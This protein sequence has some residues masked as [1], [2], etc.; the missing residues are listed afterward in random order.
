MDIPGLNYVCAE[1]DKEIIEKIKQL[2]LSCKFSD[3]KHITEPECAV[4]KAVESGEIPKEIYQQY[5]KENKK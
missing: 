1:I 3:C 2:S 4:K 5:L